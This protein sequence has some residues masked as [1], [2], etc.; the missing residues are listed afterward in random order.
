MC[1]GVGVH[2]HFPFVPPRHLSLVTVPP[3]MIL[4]S[5]VARPFIFRSRRSG[6]QPL[7]KV[8][9]SHGPKVFGLFL[10][11]ASVAHSGWAL[12]ARSHLS[13]HTFTSGHP[14]RE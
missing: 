10:G 4:L 14:L 7:S 13:T 1:H 9:T 12:P 11:N 5:T 6:A 8:T 2:H 3:P